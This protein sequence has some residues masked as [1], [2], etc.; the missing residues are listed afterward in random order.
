[1]MA[2]QLHNNIIDLPRRNICMVLN[3]NDWLQ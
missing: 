2:T 3:N 1:M